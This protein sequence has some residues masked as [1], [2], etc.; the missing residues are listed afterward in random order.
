MKKIT[1]ATAGDNGHN[2]IHPED[3]AGVHGC[4]HICLS[5][6]DVGKRNL[7]EEYLKI[8]EMCGNVWIILSIY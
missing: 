5:Q 1:T 6:R 7:S 3:V 4:S 8:S 2:A